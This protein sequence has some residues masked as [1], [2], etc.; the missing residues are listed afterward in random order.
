MLG[1][2]SIP[3][4]RLTFLVPSPSML[5]NQTGGEQRGVASHEVSNV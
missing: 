5:L 4:S 3:H 2:S 1:M